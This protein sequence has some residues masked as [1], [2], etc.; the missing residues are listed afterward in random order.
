MFDNEIN[1]ENQEIEVGIRLTD[2]TGK[3]RIKKRKDIYGYGIPVASR[4]EVFSSDCYV[5][6]QIG[7]D[8]I[9][10]NIKKLK[11]TTL[12][13]SEFIGA[14]GD[15]KALYELSEYIKYFYDWGVIKKENL[16]E[17]KNYLSNL[18]E[19]NYL[20]KNPELFIKKKSPSNKTLNGFNFMQT[21]VE[22]PLL[23]YKFD[24]SNIIA[25]IKITEKQR[26]VGVQ[27][28][29]FLCFPIM[30]LKNGANL[31]GRTAFVKEKATLIINKNNID[32]FLE[33]LKLFGTL[34][35]NHNKDVI[36]I[37]NLILS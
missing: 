30:E 17:I 34:S 14:N 12:K 13:A 5:E 35:K 37:I 10:S 6:W 26:A 19:K 9:K 21:Q 11:N 27:P 25:E 32:V 23:I 7:Y 29:L 1:T 18:T 22:Y 31:L 28:M 33:L 3:T 36:N 20:D 8:V 15:K 16:N 2:V 24:Q 4:K